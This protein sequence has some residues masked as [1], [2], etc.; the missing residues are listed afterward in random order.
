MNELRTALRSELVSQ[1]GVKGVLTD[2]T[3]LFSGGLLDSL[4]VMDLVGFVEGKIGRAIPPAEITLAN[5]D[6]IDSI[7]RYSRTLV[8]NGASA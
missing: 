2:E 3:G 1:L 7:V 5:F 8:S 6:S 4:S